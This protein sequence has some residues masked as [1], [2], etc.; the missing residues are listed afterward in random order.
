MQLTKLFLT[1]ILGLLANLALAQNSKS[2]KVT[3]YYPKDSLKFNKRVSVDFNYKN[4]SFGK[5]TMIINCESQYGHF[6][7]VFKKKIIL[8]EKFGGNYS[9]VYGIKGDG[10]F[11]VVRKDYNE[12]ITLSQHNLYA[13]VLLQDH[14]AEI[15]QVKFQ[16]LGNEVYWPEFDYQNCSISDENH[17]GMPEFYLSYMGE[18]DG[19]DAKPYKQIVYYRPIPNKWVWTK[20]KATAFYP[21]GNKNDVYRVEYDSN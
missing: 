9:D 5:T 20:A 11:G 6:E 21:A 8:L 1:I 19:L 13:F 14:G 3:Y 15:E 12:P 16:D 18:S 2:I 4:E 7:F 10:S 17:D